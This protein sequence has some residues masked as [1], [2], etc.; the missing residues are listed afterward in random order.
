MGL[1]DTFV[2]EASFSR[3][4]ILKI[5]ELRVR[6]IRRSQLYVPFVFMHEELE[7]NSKKIVFPRTNY[8]F[9]IL[10]KSIYSIDVYSEI[11]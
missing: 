3:K 2:Y 11:Y 6:L 9:Y 1:C 10:Y 8:Y 7:V 5:Y 4:S